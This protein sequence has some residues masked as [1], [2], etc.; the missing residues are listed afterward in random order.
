MLQHL[1]DSPELF[2][3]G[4]LY[5]NQENIEN[6][7]DCFESLLKKNPFDVKVLVSKGMALYKKNNPKLNE[8]ILECYNQ[9]LKQN[10]FHVKG[11]YNKGVF[12]LFEL[13]KN[14][15]AQECFEKLLKL[16][17]KYKDITT[18]YLTESLFKQGKYYAALQ[19]IDELIKT[20]PFEPYAW[21]C[22]GRIHIGL[23]EF[24]KAIE[25]FK[26]VIKIDFSNINSCYDK[27][28]I[29]VD[30]KKEQSINSKSYSLIKNA[31]LVAYTELKNIYLKLNNFH[32]V[33]N[34]EEKIR[35]ID[36]EISDLLKKFNLKQ[37]NLSEL[38]PKVIPKGTW[39]VIT[40]ERKHSKALEF[41][42]QVRKT[43]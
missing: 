25:S 30:L 33:E 24:D 27:K 26:K 7:L 13:N 23:N 9:A 10:P 11:L 1:I 16:E 39:R 38:E 31:R 18:L 17:S 32:K 5:L 3:Q 43:I 15:E 12:L 19:T 8:E 37:T 20:M 41:D 21:L 29:I 22:K 6:A 36:L 14:E 42:E 35:N 28:N 4:I 34:Y 40:E 2:K